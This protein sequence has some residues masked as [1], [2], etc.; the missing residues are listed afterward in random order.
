MWML[1]WHAAPSTRPHGDATQSSRIPPHPPLCN[2]CPLRPE[3]PSRIEV[4][5]CDWKPKRSIATGT[6]A[7]LQRSWQFEVYYVN[8]KT[9]NIE[10]LVTG[11][12][13]INR[14]D[15]TILSLPRCHYRSSDM[16]DESDLKW[17][18]KNTPGPPPVLSFLLL[19]FLEILLLR[20]G[21]PQHISPL[22]LLCHQLPLSFHL[23]TLDTKKAFFF[24]F[25]YLYKL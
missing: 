16:R 2:M 10:D 24:I 22:R 8:F 14:E 21:D 3:I 15:F 6:S 18:E 1:V 7:Y 4:E 25:A 9:W 11:W 19:V 12:N 20:E 5:W 23:L 13:N 17:G